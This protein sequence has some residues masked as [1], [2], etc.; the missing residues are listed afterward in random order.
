[1]DTSVLAAINREVVI[2]E[3]VI[4]AVVVLL[5]IGILVANRRKK[6]AT[7][8]AAA[9]VPNYYADL[10]PQPAGRAGSF[11]SLAAAGTT[12]TVPATVSVLPGA[13]DQGPVTPGVPGATLEGASP[14]SQAPDGRVPEM[15]LQPA[16][17]VQ[18]TA[19]T[20]PAVTVHPPATTPPAVTPQP[21][22]DPLWA[23]AGTPAWPAG[24]SSWPEAMAPGWL[25]TA[26]GAPAAPPSTW[27]PGTPAPGTPAGWLPDPAGTPDTLRYWD[28]N[29]WTPHFAQ[30]S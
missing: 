15:P 10:Q 11:A 12:A 5:L 18:P 16:V 20:P 23:G 9:E 4:G 2:I 29:A 22:T 13:A 7:P 21:G 27:A 24:G 14:G 19:T 28:G 8:T 26:S 6:R 25:A 1:M 3:A 30:R 17:T